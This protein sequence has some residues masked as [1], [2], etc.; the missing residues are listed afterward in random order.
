LIVRTPVS[1]DAFAS[2]Q[3]ILID[4]EKNRVLGGSDPRNKGTVLST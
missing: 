3:A 1:Y 2:P 4:H